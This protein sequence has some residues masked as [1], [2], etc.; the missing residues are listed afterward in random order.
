LKDISKTWI[1]KSKR[2]TPFQELKYNFI[3]IATNS[4]KEPMQERYIEHKL[5]YEEIDQSTL[6]IEYEIEDE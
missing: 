1:V 4:T 6:D 3:S 5:N 2:L